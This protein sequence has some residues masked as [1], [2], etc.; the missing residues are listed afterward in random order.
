MQLLFVQYWKYMIQV[1]IIGA[2]GYSGAELMRL[3]IARRD[4]T[5]AKVISGTSAGRRVDELYPAFSG[6][7]D[8][9]F[10]SFDPSQLDGLDV[11]FVALPS[12][13]GMNVVPQIMDR[14]EH[15][16]DLGGDFRLSN[17]D[18]Y[19]RF[20]GH[21]H[22]APDLLGEAVYGLPELNKE[23]IADA[24]LIANPGCY[25]TSAILP[26][27]PVLKAG[28]ISTTGI[29]INS[30][31]GVSG[32]GRSASVEMSFAEVN[33]NI[34]AYKV[35]T[36]QHIPE[37]Q[38]ILEQATGEAIGLS[39]VPHLVPLT[40]GIYTTIHADIK[41]SCTEEE[42]HSVYADFYVDAP[43]V[44]VRQT[45]PQV[46]DVAYT[47]FCDI[48]FTIEHWTNQLI[49]ISTIDNLI[50]GAA[51]QAIQNMNVMLGLPEEMGLLRKELQHV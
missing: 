41:T 10:E 45:I 13:E 44:R 11:V 39:F 4:V 21:K 16:I 29:V 36:H 47:N 48:A 17:T 1:G 2:S 9:M 26:L 8:L 28:L 30:L 20:Y 46:K 24:H 35:G 27:L 3:L 50:K 5:I 19:E 32:A 33:E 15:V 43:F 12:G 23:R 42:L 49:I 6:S 31:S 7:I 51:G 40:R 37:I 25:P 38:C 14:V 22:T 18:L 34:R